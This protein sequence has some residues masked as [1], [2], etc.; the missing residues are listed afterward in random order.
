MKK[1]VIAITGGI[2]SGKSTVAGIIKR[3]GYPVYS[4]D[5]IYHEIYPSKEYQALLKATF[6]SLPSAEIID[7]KTLAALVFSD[8]CALKKLNAISHRAIM[9]VLD[10]K[11][12]ATESALVFAE[13]PLL[14]ECGFENG[15]DY[16]LIV[17]RSLSER[18]AA[19]SARDNL[20]NEQAMQRIQSQYDYDAAIRSGLFN[21]MPYLLLKNDSDISSLEENTKAVLQKLISK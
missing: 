7:R 12:A 9:S 15:F 10:E 11:I 16:V 13:V 3:L 21:S 20:S 2:G 14:F 17:V 19:I 18:L 8:E 4:C 1:T 5:T 6:P